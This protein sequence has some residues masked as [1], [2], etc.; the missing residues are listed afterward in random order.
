M[1]RLVTLSEGLERKA[2]GQTGEACIYS[3]G[4]VQGVVQWKLQIGTLKA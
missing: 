3:C 2:Q 1:A 4:S